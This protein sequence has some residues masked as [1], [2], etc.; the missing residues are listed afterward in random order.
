M[1]HYVVSKL[2]EFQFRIN[3]KIFSNFVNILFLNK[4]TIEL[5]ISTNTSRYDINKNI[6]WFILYSISQNNISY[7]KNI[8]KF[9]IDIK[10]FKS[11]QI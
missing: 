4:L 11:I 9:A 6:V 1:N 8:L 10:E 7:K 5:K 2:N 3:F